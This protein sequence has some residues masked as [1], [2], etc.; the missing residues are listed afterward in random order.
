VKNT[1]HGFSEFPSAWTLNMTWYFLYL[2][3]SSWRNWDQTRDW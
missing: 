3:G 1:V 2:R